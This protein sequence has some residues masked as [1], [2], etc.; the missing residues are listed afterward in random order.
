M[1][2]GLLGQP[3]DSLRMDKGVGPGLLE[4]SA[5]SRGTSRKSKKG[6]TRDGIALSRFKSRALCP[7]ALLLIT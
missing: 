6:Y 3:L 2:P 4:I 1:G 5:V 7:P